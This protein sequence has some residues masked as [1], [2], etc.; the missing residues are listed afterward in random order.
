MCGVDQ[1]RIVLAKASKGQ[2]EYPALE[3]TE[4]NGTF[5]T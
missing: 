3:V 1:K 4:N 5:Q 2:R